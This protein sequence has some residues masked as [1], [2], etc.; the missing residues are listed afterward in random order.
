MQ[1][2]RQRENGNWQA[3]IKGQSFT[4]PNLDV[5]VNYRNS[6]LGFN[7]ETPYGIVN[8]TGTVVSLNRETGKFEPYLVLDNP[9]KM[10]RLRFGVVSDTHLGSK[11]EMLSELEKLYDY[12]ETEGI[13]VVFHAGNW[14]EGEANFNRHE[15]K[16]WGIDNQIDYFITKYPQKGTIKTYFISG[17]DHEGWWYIREGIDVG[18]AAEERALQNGRTDLIYIG[19]LESDIT[20]SD[21][22]ITKKIRIMHPGGGSQKSLSLKPQ[23]IIDTISGYEQL[24]L[25]I[26]GHYHKAE[27]IPNYRNIAALQAG[28]FQKQTPFLRKRQTTPQMGGWV[29]ELFKNG[30][31]ARF[32]DITKT[33]M[34]NWR[35]E[36]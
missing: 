33:G 18:K 8:N 28:S 22:K 34:T 35:H 30:I 26:I 21:G 9:I 36:T 1:Y 2:I 5:V 24:D 19:Y 15:I 23:N 10:D 17:D 6:I 7:P 27:L 14:I 12:F 32:I 3:R 16:V 20:I 13:E 31:S 4:H 29:V 11:Y 25:I